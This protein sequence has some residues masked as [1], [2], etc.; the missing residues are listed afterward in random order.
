MLTVELIFVP[1][2]P[3]VDTARARIDTALTQVRMA[4][5]RLEHDA[6]AP[7]AP[8]RIRD[9]GSPTILVNGQD[10]SGAAPATG[11]SCRLYPGDRGA[12]SLERII[13]VL[14]TNQQAEA[15]R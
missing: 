15:P 8:A 11:P 14:E 5:V 3:H 9:L 12:P 6:S 7:D 13:A 1:G 2:C 10:V 4:A